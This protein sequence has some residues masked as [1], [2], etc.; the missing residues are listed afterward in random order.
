MFRSLVRR[1]S[2]V[3]L[4]VIVTALLALVAPTATASSDDAT[5]VAIGAGGYHAC[6]IVDDGSLACWG[7]NLSGELG[8][9]TTTNALARVK[10]T[11]LSAPVV[12]V[13]AGSYHT[14]ALT[15]AGA[16]FCWGYNGNGQLGN[17][18]TT[19]AHTPVAVTGLSSDV[20]AISAGS[21][22]TCALT[23]TG[24]L[25]CWGDNGFGE[26]GDGSNTDRKTPVAIPGFAANVAGVTAGQAVTCAVT[27]AGAASCWGFNGNGR[28][29]DGTTTNR[30]APVAVSGLS[31][32]VASIATMGDHSCAVL[33]TGTV[34][35]WGG[36]EYGQLGDGTTTDR[37]TPVAVSGLTDVEKVTGG[38]AHTCALAN[39]GV[40]CWGWNNQGQLGNASMTDT[41]VPGLVAGLGNGIVDVEGA[42]MHSC[43]VTATGAVLCWGLNDMGELGVGAASERHAPT[44]AALSDDAAHVMT[45]Y[46]HSCAVTT[47]GA[48]WCWGDNSHGQIGDGTVLER[49]MPTPVAGLGAG[50]VQMVGGYEH[51]CALSGAG[52]VKCWG[53]NEYGQLGDGTTTERHAPT[54]VVGL[55]SGVVELAAGVY[56][57][58]ARLASGSV[59][60]WGRNHL[61]NAGDGTWLNNK[62]EPVQVS[63]ITAGATDIDANNEMSCAVVNGG[64]QCWGGFNTGDGSTQ[65]R[66]T[67]VAAIGLTTGVAQVVTGSTACALLDT[68]SAACWG[69]RVGDGTLNVQHAPIAVPALGAD[70]ASVDGVGSGACLLTTTGTVKCWG[71]NMNGEV[72]DGT[73]TDRLSPTSTVGLGGE[74]TELAATGD[75]VCAVLVSKRVQCWGNNF[76]GQ[77]GNG[78]TGRSVVPIGVAGLGLGAAVIASA[79]RDLLATPANGA[80][81]LTW[82]APGTN[83]GAPVYGYV[84]TVTDA[85]GKPAMVN[86]ANVR[87][88]ASTSFT[89]SGLTN[90]TDYRLDVAPLN[91][92]GRGP[93]VVSALV[94]PRVETTPPTTTPKPAPPKRG[95]WMVDARGSVYTF[96]NLAYYGGIAGGQVRDLEPLPN[97]AGYWIVN[98]PGTVRA[99]GNA[100]HYGNGGAL[101]VGE[102]V[103]SLSS[104]PTGKGYWLFTTRG[105]V[106]AR[107][108]AKSYGDLHAY[109]LNAPIVGSVATPTGKGYYL[110]AGDGGVFTFGDARFR[111]STGAMRLNAPITTLVPTAD[112][113]GYWLVATDGGVFSFNAPFRGSTGGRKLNRPIVTTVPYGNGYVMVASDGGVFSF[114]NLPFA[115]SLAGKS[116][117]Q[118]IVAVGAHG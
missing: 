103:R 37:S 112:N 65:N 71:S 12:A 79:P 23:N 102:T 98:A 36:N 9:G 33:S 21:D 31:S 8:D 1:V 44:D 53:S 34:R 39:G 26:I 107:G 3:L 60:C 74:V 57:T 5:V 80:A 99:L 29:G 94:R 83:G 87:T 84:V 22:H 24:A 108:D 32:G 92:A 100:K 16:V 63:G 49:P 48:A 68:G 67:P 104:T 6:A 25:K 28:L 10:T 14:C 47:A 64:V 90:G 45:G 43:A 95:Y 27:T 115:G 110:V 52:A 73:T 72:G 101:S 77:L 114:S 76:N 55:T 82:N 15:D 70:I 7:R 105:R 116:L 117:A 111:G 78:V 97:A 40:Q 38:N 50:V 85:D 41:S 89:F 106:F 118:P 69:E 20:V 4:P 46:H 56:H 58:C 88:T 11:G 2:I 54:T 81:S 30:N 113:T 66:T 51:T 42:A 13:A 109:R 91:R 18:T 93:S 75:H 96:G 86:G 17:G 59:K 19:S 35:C 61:G 62:L